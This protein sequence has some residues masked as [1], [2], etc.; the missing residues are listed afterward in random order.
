MEIV[1][2]L[3]DIKPEK[4]RGGKL[5]YWPVIVKKFFGNKNF[6][7][8]VLQ[9]NVWNLRGSTLQKAAKKLKQLNTTEEIVCK[10]SYAVATIYG[11]VEAVIMIASFDPSEFGGSMPELP[12]EEAKRRKKSEIAHQFERPMDKEILQQKLTE[13]KEKI[14][15]ELTK[16]AINE[17]KALKKPPQDVITILEIVCVLFRKKESDALKLLAD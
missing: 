17:L 12:P 16:K 2:V 9:F 15:K 8:K 14:D 6:L 3:F 5:D 11:W 10:K 1:G 13:A 4:Q 7:K